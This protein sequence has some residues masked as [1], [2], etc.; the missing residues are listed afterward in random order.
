MK[1]IAVALL[2]LSGCLLDDDLKDYR[3]ADKTPGGWHVEYQGSQ[4]SLEAGIYTTQ[5][6]YVLFDLAML[7]AAD[8]LWRYGVSRDWTLTLPHEDRVVFR[9]F[10]NSWFISDGNRFAAGS[11]G[12]DTISVGLY[13]TQSGP[14]G[15]PF[16][17]AALPWTCRTGTVTGN[18]YWATA[19]LTRPFP[20]LAHELGH[21]I[22][23]PEFEHSYFPPIV[24]P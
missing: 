6:L 10:D 9:L 1:T 4:G 23:G 2:L 18:S 24:N 5:E 14:P 17:A 22:F 16:P 12:G 19:D 7:R 20:A 3:N 15:T 11:Y 21:A 13:T 8:E